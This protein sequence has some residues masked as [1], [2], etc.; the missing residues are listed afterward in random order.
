[1]RLSEL[2][3]KDIISTKDG[4]KVG[5][6]ID[7]E[8]NNEDGKIIYFI[9]E[10]KSLVK[11]LIGGNKEATISFNDIAKIGQDVILVDF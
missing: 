8:L 2:Q 7:V 1:M 4:K 11:S 10:P 9:V 3:Q 6:I 5:R